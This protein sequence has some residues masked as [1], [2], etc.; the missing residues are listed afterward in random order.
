LSEQRNATKENVQRKQ[1][2][3]EGERDDSD[4]EASASESE[5][6]DDTDVPYNPKNLPLGWDGKVCTETV[7]GVAKTT[8]LSKLVSLAIAQIARC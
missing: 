1:A 8:V 3:T 6:E 4:A 5:D 2:R 7:G